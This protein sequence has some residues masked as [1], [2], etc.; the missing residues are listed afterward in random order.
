[1]PD[2]DQP[3]AL[4]SYIRAASSAHEHLPVGGERPSPAHH[5]CLAP[6]PTQSS[7]SVEG[8]LSGVPFF[9]TSSELSEQSQAVVRGIGCRGHPSLFFPSVWSSHCQVSVLRS[10]GW[11]STCALGL[12]SCNEFTSVKCLQPPLFKAAF[13]A[14]VSNRECNLICLLEMK[15]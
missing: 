12:G 6:S 15:L 8:I 13:L 7:P 3:P 11:D 9:L 5:V 4:C 10:E 2:S 14:A 1:M